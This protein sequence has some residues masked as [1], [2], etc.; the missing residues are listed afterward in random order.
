MGRPS[1][2]EEILNPESFE[3]T[4]SDRLLKWQVKYAL[5]QKGQAL[6]GRKE[7]QGDV[8]RKLQDSAFQEEMLTVGKTQALAK[9]SA[10]WKH[11]EWHQSLK[12][13]V[14]L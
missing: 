3:S 8:S 13:N 12:C 1:Y 10:T 14:S 5:D 9:S 7:R 11:G 4:S 2:S 6:E